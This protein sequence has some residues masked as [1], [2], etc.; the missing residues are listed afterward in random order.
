MATR[1]IIC[2]S[3]GMDGFLFDRAD[4]ILEENNATFDIFDLSLYSMEISGY[5]KTRHRLAPGKAFL[6]AQSDIGDA[7]GY[8]RFI[9][10]TV[11]YPENTTTVNKYLF[12]HYNVNGNPV[13]HPLGE[14][15]ILTGDRIDYP[16]DPI[17]N[18]IPK[19]TGWDLSPENGI[20]IVNPPTGVMVDIEILVAR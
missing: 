15:M 17:T 12:W 7:D 19:P 20:M 1:P 2:P 3:D 13:K 5:A 10:F 6:L 11:K 9:V 16:F 14:M 18:T 8:V 4:L